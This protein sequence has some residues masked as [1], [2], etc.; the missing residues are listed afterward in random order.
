MGSDVR[1]CQKIFTADAM[2]RLRAVNATFVPT[3]KVT[4]TGRRCCWPRT[5]VH[6]IAMRVIVAGR[7]IGAIRTLD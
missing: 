3:T 4:N 1:R 7:G 2:L 6:R 5:T